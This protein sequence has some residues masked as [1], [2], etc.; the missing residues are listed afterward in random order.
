M[1]AKEQ[2]KGD[3]TELLVEALRTAIILGELEPGQAL[4]QEELA[5][6]YSSSRMPVR[7]ALRT[8]S[9]EGLVQL[10]PNRGAIVAPI[11][12]DELQENTEMREVS[13]LLAL[14]L[15]VPHLSNAQIDEAAAIQDLIERSSIEKFGG[16]NKAFHAKLYEPCKRPRLLAHI[17]SLHDIAERYMHY[18]LSRLDY[19]EASSDE[20]RMLLDACYQ[21]DVEAAQAI[22]SNHISKA[23]VVLGTHL[24]NLRG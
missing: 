12:A 14:R 24:R 10:I 21:R 19:T 18:T 23:G 16:L 13:E 9:G 7:E 17:T 5:Q 20:H 3:R 15:A 11:N 22:L 4:R 6:N 8:L 1:Q 2:K